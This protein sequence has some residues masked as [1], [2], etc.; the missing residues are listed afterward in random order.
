MKSSW[1]QTFQLLKNAIEIISSKRISRTKCVFIYS[2][3]IVFYGNFISIFRFIKTNFETYNA[4]F[5]IQYSI[6]G[7]ILFIAL[8]SIVLFPFAYFSKKALKYVA[9][10]F[11][12]MSGAYSYFVLKLNIYISG[13]I[14]NDVLGANANDIAMIIDWKAIPV[15]LFFGIFPSFLAYIINTRAINRGYVLKNIGKYLQTLVIIICIAGIFCYKS[16]SKKYF[17][18]I[19]KQI[20]PVSIFFPTEDLIIGYNHI[21]CVI[22]DKCNAREKLQEYNI[23]EYTYTQRNSEPLIAIF[24]IGES[25]RSNRL[26]INGYYRTTTPHLEKLTQTPNIANFKDV[27]SCDILTESS[28]RCFMSQN[29]LNT[30]L[31]ENRT[32]T[33]SFS[34]IL[35]QLGFDTYFYG[36]QHSTI[37]DN[38]MKKFYD[39]KNYI[40]REDLQKIDG[41][42]DFYRDEYLINHL[43]D[44]AKR[45]TLYILHTE[46]NHKP[47]SNKST[48]EQKLFEEIT[49]SDEYDNATIA[50]DD[51][52][53]K[54]TEKF[55][56]K[57]AVIMYVSDH[58]ESF[59]E[60]NPHTGKPAWFHG[61]G[62]RDLA[63]DEQRLL[64]MFI[65][66]SNK[67]IDNNYEKFRNIRYLARKNDEIDISHDNIWHTFLDLIGVK[68]EKIDKNLSLAS[69]RFYDLK[70]QKLIKNEIQKNINNNNSVSMHRQ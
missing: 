37:T 19:K 65:W 1:Q 31:N 38:Y 23:D 63:P 25:L 24:V 59:G 41:I 57:N 56:N 45:N 66:M 39:V 9:I 11:I 62:D 22:F 51:F 10:F 8:T 48:K 61:V 60:I 18:N 34:S 55:K 5:A 52:I 58:G 47:Y 4:I 30:W 14:S 6:S 17:D 70:Q 12:I 2:S 40:V 68:S 20:V 7:I 46:G 50:F 54:L 64:P 53:F 42:T 26:S 27:L 43:N 13:E 49:E 15:L 69:A 29:N 33:K 3:I 44:K 36:N 67:Y 16:F 32:T 28:V 35:T 21:L